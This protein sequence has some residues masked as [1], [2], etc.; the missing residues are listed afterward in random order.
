MPQLPSGR[1]VGVCVS[2][3]IE[4]IKRGDF[5]LKMNFMMAVRSVEDIRYMVSLVY[6]RGED[7]DGLPT[8][9]YAPGLTLVDVDKR[10]VGWSDEDYSAFAEWQQSEPVKSWMDDSYEEIQET[11]KNL[12]VKL[13][14]NLHGILEG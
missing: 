1:H 7:S 14:K 10:K 5:S 11:V 6:Y 4:V 13:P 9:S 12:K 8:E 3:I 2:P